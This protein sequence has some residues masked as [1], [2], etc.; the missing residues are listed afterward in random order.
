MKL[1]GKLVEIRFLDH[2]IKHRG[3]KALDGD[4]AFTVYGIVTRETKRSVRLTN[5]RY[6]EVAKARHKAAGVDI[7]FNEEHSQILK[8]CIVSITLL[9]RVKVLD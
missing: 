1:L 6:D 5:W 9:A 7:E 3:V 4:I 2:H 8:S